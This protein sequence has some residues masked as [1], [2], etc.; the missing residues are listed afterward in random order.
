MAASPGPV[1]VRAPVVS[2]AIVL[3][4]VLEGLVTAPKSMP[5]IAEIVTGARIVTLAPAVAE[6][7]P[8]AMATPGMN[9]TDNAFSAASIR[10]AYFAFMFKQTAPGPLPSVNIEHCYVY[11]D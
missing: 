8:P 2:R 9:T 11:N 7:L 1:I 4:A 3:T 5:W 10:N 6:T